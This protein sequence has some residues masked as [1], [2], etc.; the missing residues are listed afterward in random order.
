MKILIAFFVSLSARADQV[1]VTSQADPRE[2]LELEFD[3]SRG[4]P[5]GLAKPFDALRTYL[6]YAIYTVTEGSTPNGHYTVLFSFGAAGD[7]YTL[8]LESDAGGTIV[9]AFY[10]RPGS[11]VNIPADA[12]GTLTRPPT[13]GVMG[14]TCADTMKAPTGIDYFE[15]TR[16]IASGGRAMSGDTRP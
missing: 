9:N 7:H 14:P 11:T 5:Y 10:T 1:R 3:I 6:K 2:G 15:I 4:A 8:Y 12:Q 16:Q 13:A